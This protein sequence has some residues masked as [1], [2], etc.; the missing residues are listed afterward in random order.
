L[1][2]KSVVNTTSWPISRVFYLYRNGRGE[3]YSAL[4]K[5]KDIYI[6]SEEGQ[7]SDFLSYLAIFQGGLLLFLVVVSVTALIIAIRLNATVRTVSSL[8]LSYE[9]KVYLAQLTRMTERLRD[10]YGNEDYQL[11]THFSRPNRTVKLLFQ[12]IW[13]VAVPLALLWVFCGVFYLT[14]QFSLMSELSYQLQANPKVIAYDSARLVNLIEVGIF[15]SENFLKDLGFPSTLLVP[16]SILIPAYSLGVKTAV[17]K[18]KAASSL[19]LDEALKGFTLNSA[20]FEFAFERTNMTSAVFKHGY[21]AGTQVLLYDT[22]FCLNAGVMECNQMVRDLFATYVELATLSL[23]ISQY[24]RQD[25]VDRMAELLTTIEGLLAFS[26]VLIVL[27]CLLYLLTLHLY[28][29]KKATGLVKLAA[30]IKLPSNNESPH[31]EI[32]TSRSDSSPS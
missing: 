23:D 18:M 7:T 5:A 6:T 32:A 27:G 14:F 3:T 15:T 17:G 24:Y 4:S 29:H 16:S 9:S 30:L 10:K 19:I 1:A 12:P 26:S 13:Y 8:L 21:R 2:L 25:G 31:A 28:M 22:L 11:I 20:H